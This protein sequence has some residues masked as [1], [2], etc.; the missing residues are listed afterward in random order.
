MNYVPRKRWIYQQQNTVSTTSDIVKKNF[1]QGFFVRCLFHSPNWLS[2]IIHRKKT[3]KVGQKHTNGVFYSAG[4]R[5][6]SP[7]TLRSSFDA[8]GVPTVGIDHSN[9]CS[10]SQY[11]ICVKNNS[12]EKNGADEAVMPL[13]E[14][15]Q[16]ST[17]Q[18]CLTA[19]FI[20][21]LH[22]RHLE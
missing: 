5:S 12:T 13:P 21:T 1:R 17:T 3:Q 16:L 6:G 14:T 4:I 2:R 22:S 11:L 18:V 15:T 8:S 20:G 19:D 10:T 7:H 9:S